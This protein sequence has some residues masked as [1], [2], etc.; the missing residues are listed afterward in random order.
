MKKN[1]RNLLIGAALAALTL[2]PA[3]ATVGILT[4]ATSM[5]TLVFFDGQG[6]ARVDGTGTISVFQTH[7]QPGEPFELHSSDGVVF[8]A[9][10]N[11]NVGPYELQS[12]LNYCLSPWDAFTWASTHFCNYAPAPVYESIGTV[13][14]YQ[15][16]R[17]LVTSSPKSTAGFSG[18]YYYD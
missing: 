8:T 12:Y 3:S 10:C 9:S 6:F 13:F 2:N 1:T 14:P 5:H 4:R 7:A 16:W 17:T 18:I 11:A 15:N